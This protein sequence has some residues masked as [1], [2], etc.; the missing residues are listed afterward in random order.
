PD[1]AGAKRPPVAGRALAGGYGPRL[2]KDQRGAAAGAMA[3]AID[4]MKLFSPLR[5]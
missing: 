1:P 2:V 3:P 4:V 5:T